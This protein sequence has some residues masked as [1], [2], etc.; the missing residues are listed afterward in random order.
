MS[1]ERAIYPLRVDWSLMNNNKHMQKND[2][3]EQQ[4]EES[5]KAKARLKQFSRPATQCK[6]HHDAGWMKRVQE[7]R[8]DAPRIVSWSELG[9]RWRFL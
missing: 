9:R 6:N 3:A 1:V 5:T 8:E 4:D 7:G 2:L